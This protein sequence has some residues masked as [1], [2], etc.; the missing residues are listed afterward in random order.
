MDGSGVRTQIP[1]EVVF[2]FR[3]VQL[4]DRALDFSFPATPTSTD[5]P[6]GIRVYNTPYGDEADD[7]GNAYSYRNSEFYSVPGS[8]HAFGFVKPATN[9]PT[10]NSTPTFVNPQTF[11]LFTYGRDGLAANIALDDPLLTEADA[12]KAATNADN[13]TNFANG[14]LETF[15]WKA[16]LGL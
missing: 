3:Q 16:S 12:A 6:P 14:R 7:R 8:Y 13:I 9:P 2:D 1:R 15:D 10:Y 4:A 11:Q 5:L